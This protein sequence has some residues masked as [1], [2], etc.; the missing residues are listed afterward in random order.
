MRVWMSD[1]MND[2]EVDLDGRA[3]LFVAG[4]WALNNIQL[5]NAR[6]VSGYDFHFR[7]GEAHHNWAQAALDLPDSL[8]WLLRDYDPDRT[9]QVYEQE[10]SE[11]EL[12]LFRVKVA[13]RSS[14]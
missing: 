12:P 1:G 5:A 8:A 4:S 2:L 6:K 7:Y 3:D 10:R 13:N 14:W 11:R 9:E